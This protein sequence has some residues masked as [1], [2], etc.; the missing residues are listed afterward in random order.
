MFIRFGSVSM[1]GNRTTQALH[2]TGRRVISQSL[3]EQG[4]RPD[5]RP[6]LARL[7]TPDVPQSPRSDK[8]ADKPKG[9]LLSYQKKQCFPAPC[10]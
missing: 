7:I 6:D 5:G 1:F 4:R 9:S 10:R 3:E 8:P 2:E